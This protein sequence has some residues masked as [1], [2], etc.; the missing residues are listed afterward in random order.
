MGQQ[1]SHEVQ[2]RGMKSS[3]HGEEQPHSPVHAEFLVL[4]FFQFSGQKHQPTS[5]LCISE[6]I[7]LNNTQNQ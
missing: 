4:F 7:S 5:K 1:E 6:N 2:Q 3:A